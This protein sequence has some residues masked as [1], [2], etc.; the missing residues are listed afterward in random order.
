MLKDTIPDYGFDYFPEFMYTSKTGKLHTSDYRISLQRKYPTIACLG[1]A[2]NWQTK[3]A[4]GCT[5]CGYKW[6]VAP[7][8]M[9]EGGRKP[10]PC[11]RC[12]SEANY[13]K[14]LAE[15]RPDI[16]VVGKYLGREVPVDHHF[17]KCDHVWSVAPK[18]SIR[19]TKHTCPNCKIISR[20]ERYLKLCEENEVK[21]LDDFEPMIPLKHQCLKCDYVWER[22]T[23][24]YQSNP[25]SCRKCNHQGAW[26]VE[27]YNEVLKERGIQIESDDYSHSQVKCHHRCLKCGN[28]WQ[29]YP[30]NVSQRRS[31]CKACRLHITPI[32]RYYKWKR[33]MAWLT[34]KGQYTGRSQS[35]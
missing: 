25:P 22:E 26:T 28:E 18:G 7:C 27:V 23:R 11:P 19:K 33:R 30:V 16:E 9:K 31:S 8:Y 6:M 29:A 5:I 34:A 2:E 3:T 32:N 24:Y 21:L 14:T 17:Q 35:K 10:Y 13:I 1:T 20:R 15:R 12:R 4:H